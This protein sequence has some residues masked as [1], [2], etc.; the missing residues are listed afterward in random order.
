MKNRFAAAMSLRSLNRKATLKV[1][2]RFF[3]PSDPLCYNAHRPYSQLNFSGCPRWSI[4][5]RMPI[6]RINDDL[7]N[8]GSIGIT[9]KWIGEPSLK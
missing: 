8:Q 9:G 4:Y 6:K 3:F 5:P 1:D 7:N 2:G